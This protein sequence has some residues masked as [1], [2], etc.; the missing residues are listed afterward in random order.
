M[1]KVFALILAI[2]YMGTSTGATLH[3]HYCMG[4]L[5]D[6]KLWHSGRDKDKCSKCNSVKKCCKDK[7]KT[8]KFEKDQKAVDNVIDV[9]HQVALG[10]PISLM[11]FRPLDIIPLIV[12]FP[13]SNAH[14]RSNKV[15]FHILNC[16]YR[17]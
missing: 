8:V 3:M 5:I 9:M 6:V 13:V 17:I 16:T 10:T 2:L 14:P 15:P 4:K 7:H 11:D 12:K 1:K